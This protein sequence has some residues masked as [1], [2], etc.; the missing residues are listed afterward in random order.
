MADDT[1][2]QIGKYQIRID[3]NLCI[4]AASCIAVSPNVFELDK[5]KKAVFKKGGSDTPENLLMA[6]QVCPTKAI[7]ITDTETG[8]LIWPV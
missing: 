5:E 2:V 4:G 6:A 7:F 1:V 3:R 8:K